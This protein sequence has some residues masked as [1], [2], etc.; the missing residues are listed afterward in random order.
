MN[1]KKVS[2]YVAGGFAVTVTVLLMVLLGF[3][4]YGELH[5]R[6]IPVTITT[7]DAEKYFD[8]KPLEAEEYE[9]RYGKID[10]DHNLA[11]DFVAEID[12]VGVVPNEITVHVTDKNGQDVT[13]LYNFDIR[14]GELEILPSPLYVQTGSVE[15]AYNST[16]LVYHEYSC[17]GSIPDGYVFVPEFIR[18][19]TKVGTVENEMIACIYDEKGM[20]T[21]DQFAIEYDF[22]ELKINRRDLTIQSDSASK[23][24]DSEPL[25]RH[26]WDLVSGSMVIG[27]T[28]NVRFTGEQVLPG[29]SDNTFSVSI[30]D[31]QGQDVTDQYLLHTQFG[32]LQVTKRSLN[33]QTESVTKIYDG[34]P[35]NKALWTLQYGELAP[36]HEMEVIVK[37]T[38]TD[39]G[40]SDNTCDVIII[41]A[42]GN[43]VTKHYNVHKNLGKLTVKHRTITLQSGSGTKIYDGVPLR[44]NSCSLTQGTL[45]PGQILDMTCT[46]VQE[47]AGSSKNEI[48]ARILD[49]ANQDVSRN[50]SIQYNVGTLT[51]Q[52][53]EIAIESASAEKR[54]DG[55]PLS[56]SQWD[57]ISGNLCSGHLIE[58]VTNGSQLEVGECD[59][60]IVSVIIYY[61]K[62]GTRVDVSKGYRIKMYPGLLS[63]TP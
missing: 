4:L 15:R 44:H 18:E 10:P 57:F 52:P 53:R 8:G 5:P 62:N 23:Q 59:N 20:D 28:L 38:Q 33:I 6:Q 13:D 1:N 56:S 41:D 14:P 37:G 39:V 27:E 50:Y 48:F 63:V 11:V 24:F 7:A 29:K 46:G 51:V 16:P 42:N 9:I 55:T 22:G 30:Q 31:A 34:K 21:T 3:I 54:Y 49:S 12:R 43:D 19:I 26:D 61:E 2:I 40:T 60:E 25:V 32:T 47:L 36:T 17:I 45:A 35:L 58:V